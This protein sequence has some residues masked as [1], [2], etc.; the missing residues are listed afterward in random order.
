M[1]DLRLITEIHEGDLWFP[2][3]DQIV[4]RT[5]IINRGLTTD[6][7]FEMAFVEFSPPL[8]VNGSRM[9]PQWLHCKHVANPVGL[10]EM[11]AETFRPNEYRL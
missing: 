10:F 8:S 3:R 5:A 9:F 1:T 6:N 4:G 11:L 2:F 7:D